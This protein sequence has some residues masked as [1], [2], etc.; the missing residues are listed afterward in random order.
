VTVGL[1]A[2]GRRSYRTHLLHFRW[3]LFEGCSWNVLPPKKLLSSWESGRHL[4]RPC[5]KTRHQ[6]S[7]SCSS[8]TAPLPQSYFFVYAPD[9]TDSD[10]LTRRLAVRPQ[11]FVEVQPHIDSGLI[12]ES[13][14]HKI[15]SMARDI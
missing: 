13:A 4:A 5:T 9:Y 14:S 2:F 7:K 15:N 1:S 3:L 11:H 8:T 12:S 6:S 10:A